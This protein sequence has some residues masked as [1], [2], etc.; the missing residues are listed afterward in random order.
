MY[1]GFHFTVNM[2]L[3]MVNNSKCQSHQYLEKYNVYSVPL[4][5][6]SFCFI[7]LF[8]ECYIQ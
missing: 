1:E 7:R 6:L 3:Y 4:T 5:P 8:I 2:K